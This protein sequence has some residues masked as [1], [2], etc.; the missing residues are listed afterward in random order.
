MQCRAVAD[1]PPAH[2]APR[3]KRLFWVGSGGEGRGVRGPAAGAL[4][5]AP[6]EVDVKR[7][8]DE[9][10]EYNRWANQRVLEAA[11]GLSD[12]QLRRDLG[13]SFAS[14]LATLEHMVLAE[15]IW[16]SRW[17]GTSPHGRPSGWELSTLAEIRER[18]AEIEADQLAF[19]T[20]LSNEDLE[21]PL[22]Y[23]TTSGQAFTSPLAQLLR[24][25]VN[26]ASYHRGQVTTMLR[27]LGA[28][29]PATDLVLF[30]RERSPSPPPAD[31]RS[32]I[33]SSGGSPHV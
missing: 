7:E 18:W 9:L 10:Y 24:H 8:I 19:L 20:A 21:R 33:P 32:P 6:R 27:Q 3:R 1:A 14:V 16:L 11:E 5:P 4:V 26:H 2:R 31:G 17:R 15:W 23:R 13:S 30:Y 12:E 28:Q 29:P 25:V 22:A